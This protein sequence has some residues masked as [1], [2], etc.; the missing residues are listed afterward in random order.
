MT[1]NE[2]AK[3][4]RAEVSALNPGRGPKYTTALR[5]RVLAWIGSALRLLCTSPKRPL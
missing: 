5:E 3:Q 2:E 1:I 4:I